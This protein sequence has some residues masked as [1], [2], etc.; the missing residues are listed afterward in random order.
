MTPSATVPPDVDLVLR[1]LGLAPRDPSTAFLGALIEGGVSSSVWRVDTATGPVCVKQPL[2]RLRVATV[3]EAPLERVM[4]EAQWL[5]SAGKIEPAAAPTVL[6]VD[7]RAHVLVMEWLEPANHPVWK[8]QLLSG[9]VVAGTAALLG[10]RLGALHCHMRTMLE[11][12]ESRA[13]WMQASQLFEALRIE[14]YLLT[15]A[16]RSPAVRAELLEVAA[17]L[18]STRT[19]VIHGD[20]SPKNVLVGP[21]GPILLD[22]ECACAGDPAFDVAFLLNH[23]LLKAAHLPAH[24]AQLRTATA[25]FWQEYRASAGAGGATEESVVHV[26]PALALAR[27]DGRSPVEYLTDAARAR[28]RARATDLVRTPCPSIDAIWDAWLADDPG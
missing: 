18:R 23:L 16:E 25:R 15:T 28:V 2:A 24:A 22:A 11:D 1:R 13:V 14:P 19:T 8:S 17:R 21:T 20:V 10:E 9:V 3:W 27:V 4:L 12:P 5:Q 6:G 26:L 7:E